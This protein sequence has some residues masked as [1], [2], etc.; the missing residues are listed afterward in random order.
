MDISSILCF[1]RYFSVDYT[2]R[3]AGIIV[4]RNPPFAP[5]AEQHDKAENIVVVAGIPTCR[6]DTVAHSCGCARKASQTGRVR[7]SYAAAIPV[8]VVSYPG[9]PVVVKPEHPRSKITE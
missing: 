8:E 9:K 1:V 3:F 6:E 2:L 7:A 4:S 5:L